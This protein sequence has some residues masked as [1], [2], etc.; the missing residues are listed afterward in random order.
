MYHKF[1]KEENKIIPFPVP[2]NGTGLNELMESAEISALS[3]NSGPDEILATITKFEALT[4]NQPP[5]WR[6]VAQSSI[7]KKLK[8]IKKR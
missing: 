8:D 7:L 3:E 4:N 6:D 2:A 5:L 1:V